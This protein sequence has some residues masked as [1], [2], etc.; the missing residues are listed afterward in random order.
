M[1]SN[2]G[3]TTQGTVHAKPRNHNLQWADLVPLRRHDVALN[4]VLSAPWLA[5]S[6]WAAQQ[7]LY[8]LAA[9]CSAAFFLTGLRQAHD[10]YHASIGVP[11]KW[12][13]VVMLMLTLTML[14]ST[15]AIRHT[16]LA[17]HRNP[18][19]EGDEEGIWAKQSACR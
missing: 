6:L 5:A 4:L 15:H 1:P 3:K 11:K 7:N 19:G 17:H 16:H 13:D 9:P 10:S 18:L 12:L 8:W 2:P 14:C